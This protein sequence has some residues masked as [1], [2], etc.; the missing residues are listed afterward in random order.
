[1]NLKVRP[2]EV[3]YISQV[4]PLVEKYL[5]DA[6]VEGA[7]KEGIELCYNLHHVQAFLTTGTWLLLVAVDEQNEI[8]GASTVSFLNYPIHRVAFITL[9]GGQFIVNR[10][11]LKQLW[12]ILKQRGATK[13]QAYGRDSMV[14]LLRRNGFRPQTTLLE[15]TL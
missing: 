2:V 5:N 7:E 3:S 11:V 12:L 4:W 13:V 10:D 8:H 15:L 1:M 9:A 14:R 6:L